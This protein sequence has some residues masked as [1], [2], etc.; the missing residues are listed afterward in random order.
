MDRNLGD[1]FFKGDPKVVNE[2]LKQIHWRSLEARKAG[3]EGLVGDS[4]IGSYKQALMGSKDG[5]SS[6]D[7][8]L[9][10]KQSNMNTEG[11]T[12]VQR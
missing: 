4:E 3:Q 11:W 1:K 2:V 12:I 10:G 7:K 8:C 6:E 5:K 9:E